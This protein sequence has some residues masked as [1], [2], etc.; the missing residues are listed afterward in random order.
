[1]KEKCPYLFLFMKQAERIH[2]QFKEEKVLGIYQKY[3]RVA[4]KLVVVL[5]QYSLQENPCSLKEFNELGKFDDCDALIQLYHNKWNKSKIQKLNS[6][7]YEELTKV[8]K[9][10]RIK[11]N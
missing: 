10:L 2:A 1:M 4:D 5:C 9:A 8:L 6:K 7:G 3:R 11:Q